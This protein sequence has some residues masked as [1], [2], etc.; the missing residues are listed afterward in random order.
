MNG[1]KP[2]RS[3]FGKN[4]FNLV[5]VCQFQGDIACSYSAMIKQNGDGQR[6]SPKKAITN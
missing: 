3:H 5:Q 4:S 6:L 2:N 1:I